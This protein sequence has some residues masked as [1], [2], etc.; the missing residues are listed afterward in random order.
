MNAETVAVGTEILLGQIV[1]TNSAELGKTLAKFG[2][3]HTHR[4]TVGDNVSRL[5]DA[6]RLA[7]SRS[8]IVFTIGGL[9]PT[10]DDITRD[11]IVEAL[12]D[13]RIYDKS[14][15]SNIRSML[16]ARGVQL[17]PSM[18]N[19]AFR[20]SCATLI[21]NPNGTAPGL[22]CKSGGKTLIAMPGPRSEFVPMLEGPV[23]EFL[24]SI[25]DSV[26]H[27]R[28]LRVAG[29]GESMIEREI[30]D[31]MQGANPTVA[32]Y[33]KVGEVHLR[34]SARAANV[35]EAEELID[36]V[37]ESIR[38]VLGDAV[39]AVDERSL[40]DIVVSMLLE[41]KETLG[42]AESCTGGGL[43]A[44]ITS[45][46][47][48]SNVFLG[49]VI[50]YSNDM[51]TALL[52]VSTMTLESHGAVSEQSALE[53]AQGVREKTGADWGVSITGIAGPGGGSE[54]KPVGLVFIGVSNSKETTVSKKIF[55]GQRDAVRARSI[56][57]ALIDLHSR[58]T[59]L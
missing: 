48:A 20:P 34:I 50:T 39:F 29:M 36:P 1:D 58:L 24:Q 3:F 54:E 49:G 28:V 5:V 19:Q 57:Q 55:P 52:G 12:D 43:G 27:S 51:K 4:Q 37:E 35:A 46:A 44:K 31:L 59:A 53:M 18:K 14:I 30:S 9:G 23:T 8:D 21:N 32:P 42:V 22:L 2:V 47:G 26:I 15:E 7:L 11:G 40:Q 17:V 16:Q 45:V 10:Q 33:A 6:L 41:R 13:E 56:Q 25:S 38:A